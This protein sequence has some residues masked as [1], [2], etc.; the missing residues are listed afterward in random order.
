MRRRESPRTRHLGS[1]RI[2]SLRID[3]P[4]IG[5]Q[6]VSLIEMARIHQRSYVLVPVSVLVV[7]RYRWMTHPRLG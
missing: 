4:P 7:A 6:Q 5:S 3:S 1:L 2:G